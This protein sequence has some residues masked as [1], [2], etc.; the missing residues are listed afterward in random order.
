MPYNDVS[1][2]QNLTVGGNI[3]STNA[4]SSN[5]VT[6]EEF[7]TGDI[8]VKDNYIATT[9]SN[10]NLEL[11]ANGTGF[12]VLEEFN[13]N[14]NVI[15]SNS[16]NDIVLT[17]GTGK[18]VSVSSNQSLIIP[19]GN[20]AE[21]PTA[22]S[23]MIRFNSQMGR[24]EGYDGVNWIKLSGV[25]DLDETTYITAE[26]TPGANDDTIRFYNN[27]ALTAD[28]TSARLQA[29][30]IEVDNLI[31]DGNTISS[32]TDTDII[33][34]AT[35]AGSIRLA[36]FAIKDNTITNTVSDAVTTITQTGTGYFK[37][38]GTNGFVV[39][40][41]ISSERPTAYAVVGMTRYNSELKQLEIYNGVSWDSAA[42]AGGGIN[43]TTAEDIAITYALI[44]G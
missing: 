1:L 6:A 20:T 26:L 38:A 16:S 39:P 27:N 43:A 4:L 35:G 13:V 2:G 14:A 42:G 32:T 19:V 29:P 17:P 11:R 23:G 28:L 5:R 37:I 8:L 30:R 33:F 24:Y 41:G 10:S 25:G 9:V 15:S 12:I 18:V 3:S 7:F 34:N 44:L 21:R 22:E 31:I 40:T 36:N